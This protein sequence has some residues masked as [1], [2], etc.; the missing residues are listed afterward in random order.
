MSPE[1][2]VKIK[3]WPEEL[4][5]HLNEGRWDMKPWWWRW[6]LG[7]RIINIRLNLRWGYHAENWNEHCDQEAQGD[8]VENEAREVHKDLDT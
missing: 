1:E 6:D 4:N 5:L 7:K 2:K 3:W 8:N